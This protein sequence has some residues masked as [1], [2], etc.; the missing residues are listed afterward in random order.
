L[1]PEQAKPVVAFTKKV[2]LV[3]DPAV[4]KTSLVRRFVID[5][6]DDAYIQ[7]LGAKVMKKEVQVRGRGK[8][9]DVTMMIW[10]VMGQ[11]HFRII[12][13]VAFQHIAGAM[14]VCDMTRRST[15]DNVS[16]WIEALERVGG[17]VP[18]IIMANKMDLLNEAEF[19]ENDVAKFALEHGATFFVTSA[20]TGENVE[21]AFTSLAKSAM[22]EGCE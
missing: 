16:Y 3:G 10:D 5:K 7:T 17:K 18:L 9:C 6:Y 2:C 13:S 15:L 20:K 8:S 1:S 12:E 4:G 14:V 22:K 19:S 21:S 11:K